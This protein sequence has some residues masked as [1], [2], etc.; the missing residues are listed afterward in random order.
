MKYKLQFHLLFILLFITNFNGYSQSGI[1]S[2]VTSK[3]KILNRE[4]SYSIYLPPSYEKS[5]RNYPVLY[6][7][8][9]I[10]GDYTD[11]VNKGELATIANKSIASESAPEMIIVVPDGMWDVFYQ[12]TIDKSV[13]W[14]DY[15]INELIP[16]VET[17]YRIYKN[18]NFFYIF[19]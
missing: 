2:T 18:R 5:S 9:G 6:L 19:R 8:H 1:V 7:F 15:F 16:D 3:S 11:W 10:W 13:M 12:N 17:K 14:E 4:V